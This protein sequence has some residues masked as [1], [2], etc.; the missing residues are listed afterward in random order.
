MHIIGLARQLDL[1][2]VAEGVKKQEQAD[3]L[4]AHGVMICAGMAFLP[5]ARCQ[6]DDQDFASVQR[7]PCLEPTFPAGS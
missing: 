2:T 5:A 6:C 7:K 3:Y 4:A 1:F